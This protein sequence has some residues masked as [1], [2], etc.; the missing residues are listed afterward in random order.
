MGWSAGVADGIMSTEKIIR[1]LII[2]RDKSI[3]DNVMDS[4]LPWGGTVLVCS[5]ETIDGMIGSTESTVCS[6]TSASVSWGWGVDWG[7]VGGCWVWASGEEG[8]DST[9]IGDT[10]RGGEGGTAFWRFGCDL[11]LLGAFLL[12][13]LDWGHRHLF[14]YFWSLPICQFAVTINKVS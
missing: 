8:D 3:G 2:W 14:W 1:L 5:E 10:R 11:V 12:T 7:G 6:S 13:W 9:G 4:T